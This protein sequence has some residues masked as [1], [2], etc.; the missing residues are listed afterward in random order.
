[1]HRASA[2]YPQ[3]PRPQRAVIPRPCSTCGEHAVGATWRTADLLDVVVECEMCG[4]VYEPTDA[5][6][7][8]G[9]LAPKVVVTEVG[10]GLHEWECQTCR[11]SG[12][13]TQVVAEAKAREHRCEVIL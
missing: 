12:V 4:Q 10:E 2:K 6:R 3:A 9:W 7:T 5:M 8:L 11:E 13:G 1:V